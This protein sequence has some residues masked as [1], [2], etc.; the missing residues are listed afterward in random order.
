M[1]RYIVAHKD[2]LTAKLSY[3]KDNEKDLVQ[4]PRVIHNPHHKIVLSQ[5]P[6]ARIPVQAIKLLPPPPTFQICHA[7]Q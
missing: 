3:L 1:T 2:E 4:I 7:L 5:R 6:S